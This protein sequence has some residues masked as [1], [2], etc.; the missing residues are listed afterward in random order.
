[1]R[2]PDSS[3]NTKGEASKDPVMELCTNLLPLALESYR[4][5]M[6]VP[7]H[8]SAA[9]SGLGFDLLLDSV[10]SER[11]P[12]RE[13]LLVRFVSAV[14]AR[15]LA[16]ARNNHLIEAQQ[17]LSEGRRVLQSN[18]L[19]EEGELIVETFHEAVEA[20]VEYKRGNISLARTRVKKAL[21]IDS[22][23]I[24]QFGYNILD[25]H[26]V[27][28]G[29]NLMRVDVHCGNFVA[30]AEMCGSLIA[31]LEGGADQWP[32]PEFS[33]KTDPSQLPSNLLSA[34]VVQILGELALFLIGKKGVEAVAMFAPMLPHVESIATSNCSQHARAHRWLQAKWAYLN[35]ERSAF[36][37]QVIDLLREGPGDMLLL[38]R[39]AAVDLFELCRDLKGEA[40]GQIRSEIFRDSQTWVHASRQLRIRLELAAA[41]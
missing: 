14:R 37:D 16:A 25:L 23:L 3:E 4:V 38:W 1:M 21:T 41:A 15:G 31:Y 30:A 5:G 26:R 6:K 34:M 36:L 40:A 12:L 13:Q 29:H 39:T 28:L 8:K 11:L 32:L 2:W 35:E 24:T 17:A 27:Q 7:P 20:Y 33:I 19:S 18:V 10:L 9:A 22:T